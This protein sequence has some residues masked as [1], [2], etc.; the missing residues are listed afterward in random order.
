MGKSRNAYRVLVGKSEGRRT[1]ERSRYR[2]EDNIKMGLCEKCNVGI[3]WIDLSHD[4]DRWL[5]VLN[6]IM[7]FSVP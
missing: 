5:A 2:W 4:R 6:A 7:N 1:L 3:Y